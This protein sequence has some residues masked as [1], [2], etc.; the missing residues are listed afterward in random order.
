MCIVVAFSI[1]FH[2]HLWASGVN[3]RYLVLRGSQ[4]KPS[5]EVMRRAGFT[6]RDEKV[7]FNLLLF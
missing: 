1:V 3:E 7:G 6:E 4:S 5:T 2:H